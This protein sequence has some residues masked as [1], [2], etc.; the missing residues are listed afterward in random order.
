MGSFINVLI[1]RVPRQIQFVTGRSVCTN[2]NTQIKNVDLVPIFSFIALGGKCRH[3]KSKI[4]MR[5]PLVELLM[6]L[7]T[8]IIFNHH[9][10]GMNNFMAIGFA[11]TG[12]TALLLAITMVDI[13]TMT[14]PDGFI[15][16]LVPFALLSIWL[17]PD[18]D[19]L[20]RLIGFFCVSAP[21]LLMA[22]IIEGSFG[23]GDIKLMAVCG[24]FLGWQFTLVAMFMAIMTGG[25]FATY[26]MISGKAKKG[27]HM[28]FGPFLCLGIFATMA[29]GQNILDFYMNFF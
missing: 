5:Y 28:A 10:Q 9:L 18:I 4:S 24:F 8:A 2:C 12:V 17:F 27:A 3:C 11:L 29:F 14:I 6:G 15:L 13:D 23:G 7:L 25:I 16:A 21:L 1:Y 26:L 22:Y 19:L 20:S